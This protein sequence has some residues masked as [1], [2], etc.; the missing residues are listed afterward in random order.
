MS[1]RVKQ[2]LYGL[3]YLVIF[4]II[5]TGVYF[6]FLKPVPSCFDNVQNQGETGVDC[7]GPCAKVC[8]P[9]ATASITSIGTVRIFSPL[10]GHATVIAQL[11]NANSDLAA[12]SFDYVVTLYGADGS[13]TVATFPRSSFAYAAET[14]WLILPNEPVSAQVSRADISVSNIQWVAAPAMGS[15]P[16]F[17]FTNTATV[18]VTP[19]YV[20]ASGNITDRDLSSF[21]N[22]IVMAIFKDA[23]GMPVGASAT[24]LDS[25]APGQTQNFSISYPATASSTIS[26]SETELHAYADRN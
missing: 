9:A 20:T 5:V 25:L 26:T 12:A 13:T 23:T 11:E 15:V 19:G 10:A 16:A 24:E 17:T 2:F 6:L 1:R 8:L 18:I 3:L 4:G 22:I 21:K 7:G 14:K